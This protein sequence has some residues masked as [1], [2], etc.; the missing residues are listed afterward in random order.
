MIYLG[1]DPGAKGAAVAIILG[2]ISDICR[3]DKT[4]ESEVSDFLLNLAWGDVFCMIE[5]LQPM[6]AFLGKEGSGM[7]GSISSFKVGQ[8]YGFLRG[9]LTAHGIPFEEVR[10]QDWQKAM[11][12]RSKGDKR[13][14]R[15][16]AQQLFPS[17]KVIHVTADAMLIAE[18][19]RRTLQERGGR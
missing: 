2:K 18:Y 13:I 11:G 9:L 4:T 6:P 19:C 1:I 16:R 5:K 14:T 3:F 15:A 7:R 8:S 12:C 17:E 10:A